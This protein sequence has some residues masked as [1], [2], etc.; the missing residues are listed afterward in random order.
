MTRG[1]YATSS[2]ARRARE[3]AESEVVAGR[4]K[5]AQLF[6]ENKE[7]REALTQERVATTERERRLVAL[8]N[9]GA[10]PEVE[11]LRQQL[12]RARQER[13]D[14]RRELAVGLSRLMK[15]CDGRTTRDFIAE[16]LIFLDVPPYEHFSNE[17]SGNRRDRRITPEKGR[18]NVDQA[19][20]DRGETK[21]G[22]AWIKAHTPRPTPQP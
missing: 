19:R 3:E 7:L 10:S 9:E 20:Q 5:I 8:M 2:E 4:R 18:A 14:V 13:D 11:S 1:R 15:E 17:W 22:R 6:E 16:A 21:G 12:H